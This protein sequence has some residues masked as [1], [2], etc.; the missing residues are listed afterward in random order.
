MFFK[1]KKEKPTDGKRYVLNV[2][3]EHKEGGYS[4]HWHG[5]MSKWLFTYD[6]AIEKKERIQHLYHEVEILEYVD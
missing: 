6:E 4:S 5:W 3:T 1:R 2:I